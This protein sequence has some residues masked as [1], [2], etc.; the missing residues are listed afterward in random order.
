M[1]NVFAPWASKIFFLGNK[2]FK[3]KEI[4][5]ILKKNR[6][7][8]IIIELLRICRAIGSRHLKRHLIDLRASNQ[9]S[10]V[11]FFKISISACYELLK[12]FLFRKLD[13]PP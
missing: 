11:N 7:S 1:P 3:P 9:N 4:E 8:Y 13:S 12:G 5:E 2:D 10:F 6:N